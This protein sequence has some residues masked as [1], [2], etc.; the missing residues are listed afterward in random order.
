LAL[1][2]FLLYL[3]QLFI[4]KQKIETTFVLTLKVGY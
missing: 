4:S 3:V 1:F 2:S